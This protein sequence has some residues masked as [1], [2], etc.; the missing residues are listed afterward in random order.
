VV[1]E[2]EVEGDDDESEEEDEV[3]VPA[4][5]KSLKQK[6]ISKNVEGECTRY[7]ILIFY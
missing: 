2:V 3:P 5:P 4:T 7:L 1:E 6:Q